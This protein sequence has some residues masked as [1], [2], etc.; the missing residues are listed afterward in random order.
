[1][2]SLVVLRSIYPSPHGAGNLQPEVAMYPR[3]PAQDSKE[4]EDL[5]PDSDDGGKDLE[6]DKDSIPQSQANSILSDSEPCQDDLPV[7]SQKLQ[8]SS[9]LAQ[10]ELSQTSPSTKKS[11]AL[12]R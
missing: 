5:K 12:N 6:S 7:G 10:A 9:T 1:M 2:C 4:Y 11:A 3:S 8:D